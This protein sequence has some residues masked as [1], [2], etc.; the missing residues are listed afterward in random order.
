MVCL[1]CIVLHVIWDTLTGQHYVVEV[2]QPHSLPIDRTVEKHLPV[3]KCHHVCNMA[4]N[5]LQVIPTCLAFRTRL[6]SATSWILE[7]SG[8]MA[9]IPSQLPHYLNWNASWLNNGN[10]FHREWGTNVYPMLLLSI[11]KRLTDRMHQ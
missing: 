7:T 6:K 3:S 4:K 5:C 10:A 1:I 9:F 11:R 8:Y 2:L